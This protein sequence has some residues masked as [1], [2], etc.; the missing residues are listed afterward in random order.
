MLVRRKSR[1]FQTPAADVLTYYAALRRHTEEVG[2]IFESTVLAALHT[3]FILN[4]SV[5]D[6][7]RRAWKAYDQVTSNLRSAAAAAAA[8][9]RI[10]DRIDAKHRAHFTRQARAAV[11][12]DVSQTLRRARVNTVVRQAVRD[13]AKRIK[14]IRQSFKRRA[15]DIIEKALLSGSDYASI[16]KELKA[17]GGFQNI[18]SGTEIRRAK[19]IARD[20]AQKLTAAID[21]ARQED[22]GITHYFWDATIDERTDEDHAA[23]DGKRFAWVRPPKTGHPGDRPNCRCVARPDFST[24]ENVE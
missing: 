6:A 23:N 11:G 14:S 20:Q 16:R 19:F 3:D 4:D 7:L 21:H 8:F 9:R 18:K 24:M 5:M 10:A 12:V 15:K 1:G 2:V 13:N 17:L 22:A